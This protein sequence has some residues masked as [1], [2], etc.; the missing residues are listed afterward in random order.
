MNIPANNF[1]VSSF[2]LCNL[3]QAGHVMFG[4]FAWTPNQYQRKAGWTAEQLRAH[5]STVFCFQE[6]WSHAALQDVFA[7]AQITDDTL[8]NYQLVCHDDSNAMHV[9]CAVHPD[10][11]IT[12][13][14]WI[15]AF[16]TELN[17][18]SD[19]TRYEMNLEIDRFSRPVLKLRLRGPDAR[20]LTVFNTHLKSRLPIPPNNESYY[21][22]NADHW[23][24]IGRALAGMR[25]LAEAAVLRLL[26]NRQLAQTTDAVI[27]AGDCNDRLP[28]NVL[29]VLKGDTRFRRSS[30]NRS[31]R[32]ADWGLYHLLDLAADQK[33]CDPKQNDYITFSGDDEQLAL[34]HLL[35]SWH[36]HSR[37]ADCRW[38]LQSWQ[39]NIKHLGS[40]KP[41]VSDHA[42][43]IACFKG[44]RS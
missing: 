32:R 23:L 35:F 19:D 31:G 25:R 27:V 8:A 30:K 1:S 40:G 10:W 21:G 3:Q 34:D 6:V 14:E 39:L 7:T 38:Q 18:R 12:E 11:E 16:P 22:T 17:W 5:P 33:L 26:V 24:D 2:N 44:S 20:T 36:F 43:V 28:G 42:M 37:A 29:D 15:R 9:A 41:H 4:D 13:Q